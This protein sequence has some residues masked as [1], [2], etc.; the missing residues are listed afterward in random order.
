MSKD[1]IEGAIYKDGK[2]YKL[3]VTNIP[4]TSDEKPKGNLSWIR[5]W[6]FCKY[7][8]FAPKK[9][10]IKCANEDCPNSY[11]I[12]DIKNMR[13]AHVR[14]KIK[15][16][17]ENGNNPAFMVDGITSLCSKCNNPNNTKPMRIKNE[18]FIPLV[19]I[20]RADIDIIVMDEIMR[21]SKK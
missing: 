10:A 12:E 13:G 20:N 1:R 4:D 15:L 16:I 8:E 6:F 7:N 9:I 21:F 11:D 19:E 3:D 14:N 18:D 17:R 2:P 5:L